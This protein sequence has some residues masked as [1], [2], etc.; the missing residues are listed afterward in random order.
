MSVN[1]WTKSE[2]WAWYCSEKVPKIKMGRKK[3]DRTN[4]EKNIR[5]RAVVNGD[6]L[7]IGLWKGCK[8]ERCGVY[9]M[10]AAGSTNVC[11][12]G[13][14]WHSG[15]LEYVPK[16]GYWYWGS[17]YGTNYDVISG[18]QEALDWLEEHFS[19]PYYYYNYNHCKHD[20]VDWIDD[21]EREITTHRRETVRKNHQKRIDDWLED[22]PD[23]PEDIG[24]F[25]DNVVFG[26]LH[27]AFGS[28]GEKEYT[29]SACLTRVEGDGWKHNKFYEC[30]KCG[31]WVKCNKTA[32][33]VE[34]SDHLMIV[35]SY[36]DKKGEI[37]SIKREMYVRKTFAREGE[38]KQIWDGSL[39]VLPLDGSLAGGNDCYYRA[40]GCWSD[41]NWTMFSHTRC[42]CYPELSALDGTAYDRI[43]IEAAARKGWK[44]HYNNMMRYCHDEP[45]MEYLV[46][47]NFYGLVDDMTAHLRTAGL[48]QGDNA[49]DV[50]GLDG[51]GVAR[52]RERQ[53]GVTYLKWLRS[54]FMCGFK[55]PEKTIEYFCKKDITPTDVAEPLKY[56]SPEQIANYIE[57]QRKLIQEKNKYRCT[58]DYVCRTWRDTLQFSGQFKLAANKANVFPKDLKERHAELVALQNL[59]REREKAQEREERF[60][61]VKP[62]CDEIRAVYEWENAEYAVLVPHCVDDVVREGCLLRHCVGTPDHEG[63]YRYLERIQDNESYIMFLRKKK[64]IEAPWYTMEVEPGGAV[65]Q[66]RT[67]GDDEG[68]DRSEAKA[69]LALWRREVAKRVGQVEREAAEVSR[70][71]R[72]REFEELRRN[73]NIIR[74]GKLAGKLLV[75]VLEADFR[76]YNEEIA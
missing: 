23:L 28:K 1:R 4:D 56:A 58:A 31:A 5:L 32:D 19:S 66:L 6:R 74:N 16:G 37:C 24:E 36:H 54:A 44:L 64:D 20:V 52:L 55:I 51:Q 71:K 68:K 59:E 3:S 70:E 67:T 57:K 26:G 49:K 60:P 21:I 62:I 29:C 7:I 46:K 33:G 22:L 45:R 8:G 39:I 72:L 69:A 34:C 38:H 50:L 63:R 10:T 30:P 14:Y 25:V 73:G 11:T 9:Y 13:E 41:K 53:G 12:D 47:G 48:M 65:R 40:S 61:R 2:I 35:Q 75:E 76:E 43:S 42:Y 15:K 27:Y 17:T 18:K